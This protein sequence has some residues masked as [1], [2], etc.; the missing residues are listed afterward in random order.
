MNRIDIV[1]LEPA[2]P[3]S[4]SAPAFPL[5]AQGKICLRVTPQLPNLKMI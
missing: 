4:D 2:K 1:V 3:D 5:G